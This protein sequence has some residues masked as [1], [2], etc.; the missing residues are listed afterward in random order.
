MLSVYCTELNISH[1][2]TVLYAHATNVFIVLHLLHCKMRQKG[3]YYPYCSNYWL[4]VIVSMLN[5]QHRLYV[6]IVPIFP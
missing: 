6:H 3:Y 2:S 1:S 5:T 4:N